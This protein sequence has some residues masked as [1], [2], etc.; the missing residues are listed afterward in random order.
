MDAL[1]GV[2]VTN[3]RFAALITG[4]ANEELVSSTYAGLFELLQASFRS[5]EGTYKK[6]NYEE[7]LEYLKIPTEFAVSITKEVFGSRRADIDLAALENRI[8]LPGL[9]SFK[10]RVDVAIS[11]SSL[12]RALKPSVYVG[13]ITVRVLRGECSSFVGRL[14]FFG[15]AIPPPHEEATPPPH[16]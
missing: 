13:K 7:D 1:A 9:K 4:E 6:R 3:E 10:W 8:K 2:E 12:K 15:G 16:R 11:T 5:P 14:V